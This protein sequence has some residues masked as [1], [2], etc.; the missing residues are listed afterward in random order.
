VLHAGGPNP[1]AGK[2]NPFLLTLTREDQDQ[3]L[4]SLAV[5]LPTGLLAHINST[6]LCPGTAAAAGTCSD[7]SKVGSVTVGAGAGTNPFYITNGRA[8]ITGP[9]KGASYGLS[10]VIP[11]IAGPFDLGNVVVRSAI[12]VDR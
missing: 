6:V 2:D 3:D 7:A 4:A 11:A 1:V 12:Y 5:N 8:Y 10:V 9:Y